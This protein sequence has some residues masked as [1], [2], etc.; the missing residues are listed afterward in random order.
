[1]RFPEGCCSNGFVAD[2]KLHFLHCMWPTFDLKFLVE[3][4]FLLSD[5][6]IYRR[7]RTRHHRERTEAK[8]LSDEGTLTRG[9]AVS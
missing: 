6:Y 5:D 4:V 1:M 8:H 7:S 9:S 3:T 2:E